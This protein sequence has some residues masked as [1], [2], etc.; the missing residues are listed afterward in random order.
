MNVEALKIVFA[1]N[2]NWSEWATIGVFIG[3]LGD[4]LVIFLFRKDKPKSE[5]WLAF[6]CTLIIAGGV[7]GEYIFG[8]RASKAADELQQL[9]DQKVADS[10][11]EAK[12]AG[13]DAADA[14]E[15]AAT[16]ERETVLLR[17]QVITQDRR[18]HLLMDKAHRNLFVS[19]I[20]PFTGQKFDIRFCRSPDTEISFLALTFM[21]TMLGAGWELK[22]F[23]PSLG[24]SKGMGLMFNPR[25]P[26][27]TKSAAAVL[28]RALFDVGLVNTAKPQFLLSTGGQA[29]PGEILLEPSSI[30]T[31]AVLI[32]SHP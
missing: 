32:D 27:S 6:A 29:A 7:Y 23:S 3:L 19:R 12:K 17:K 11:K 9:S 21:G 31:I 10:N 5:T 15:R 13:K 28:Q 8:G 24:C 1:T 25:A 4:I 26:T 2:R 22:E 18:E 20:R 16:L 14:N 30:D